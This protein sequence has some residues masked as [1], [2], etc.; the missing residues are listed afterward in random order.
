MKKFFPALSAL[1]NFGSFSPTPSSGGMQPLN[2][3][4]TEYIYIYGEVNLMTPQ[5]WVG[6]RVGGGM[7]G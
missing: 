6:V 5:I 2:E 4:N 7:D 1:K 3:L